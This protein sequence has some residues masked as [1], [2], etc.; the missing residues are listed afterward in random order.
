MGSAAAGCYSSLH[1]CHAGLPSRSASAA[2]R[3][4]ACRLSGP[5]VSPRTYLRAI[6]LLAMF[7]L[8]IIYFVSLVTAFAVGGALIW[9]IVGPVVLLATLYL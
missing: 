1:V 3:Y 4:G 2:K 9:T 5:I 6:H 7:P 8:G